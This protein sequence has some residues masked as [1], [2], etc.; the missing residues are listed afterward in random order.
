MYKYCLAIIILRGIC[1]KWS[2]SESASDLCHQPF[3]NR[4]V[5][6]YLLEKD[7]GKTVLF[8]SY[9]HG[10]HYLL[11]LKNVKWSHTVKL[12]YVWTPFSIWLII[13]YSK[14]THIFKRWLL[15]NKSSRIAFENKKVGGKKLSLHWLFQI[16]FFLLHVLFGYVNI[17]I[18]V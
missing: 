4:C 10:F 2:P 7:E 15:D 3:R 11:R 12:Y 6:V 14:H 16:L 17:S 9:I 18:I 5:C 1:F 8:F 13:T